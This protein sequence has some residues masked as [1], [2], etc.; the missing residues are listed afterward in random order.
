M[1]EE[2]KQDLNPCLRMYDFFSYMSDYHCLTLTDTEMHD[3]ISVC[4]KYADS[5]PEAVDWY[6]DK[7]AQYR[8]KNR[9]LEAEVRSLKAE[10]ERDVVLS[11]EIHITTRSMRL[12]L[13]AEVKRLEEEVSLVHAEAGSVTSFL[14]RERDEYKRKLDGANDTLRTISQGN[15]NAKY[16]AKQALIETGEIT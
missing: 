2:N 10:R 16:L 5:K 11:N 8:K 3:I 15:T 1:S 12:L 14:I 6:I 7:A 9:E 13:E 4:A